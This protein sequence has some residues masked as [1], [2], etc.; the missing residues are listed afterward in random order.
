MWNTTRFYTG[1]LLFIIYMNDLPMAVKN[2]K[3]SMYAY[4]TFVSNE[5]KSKL[6][7]R[8]EPYPDFIKICEWLKADKLSLNF[9]KTEFML[10]GNPRK[11]D[12]LNGLLALRVGDSLIR[13]VKQTKVWESSLIKTCHGIL[14]LSTFLKKSKEVLGY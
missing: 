7:I 5:T 1:T 13:R 12:E 11:C 8:D 2:S 10:I 4:Y 14:T 6:D 9:L 3:I